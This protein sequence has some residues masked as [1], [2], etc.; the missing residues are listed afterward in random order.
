MKT[1]AKVGLFITLS[2]L[3]L[4]A[5]LTQLSSFDNLFKK[6]YPLVAMIKDG[7]GLKEKAKVKLKGVNIGYVKEVSLKIMMLWLI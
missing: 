7:S 1:E 4:F 3:F 6:S 5:L 2:L